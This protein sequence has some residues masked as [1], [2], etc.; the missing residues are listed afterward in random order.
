MEASGD[1]RI[2]DA[3]IAAGGVKKCLLGVEGPVFNRMPDNTI[4]CTGFDAAG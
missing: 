4:G 2:G 3:G 1:M